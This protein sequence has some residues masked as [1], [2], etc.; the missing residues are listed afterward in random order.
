MSEIININSAS[1]SNL[2]PALKNE[3]VRIDKIIHG[4][5]IN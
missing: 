2:S 5:Q 4:E 3:G 1:L